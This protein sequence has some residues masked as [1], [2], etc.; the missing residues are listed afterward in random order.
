[1]SVKAEPARRRKKSAQNEVTFEEISVRAYEIYTL[2]AGTDSTENWLQAEAQ[3]S[4]ERAGQLKRD[5][6]PVQAAA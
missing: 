3:L 6:A 4:A 1:M 5:A 2:D